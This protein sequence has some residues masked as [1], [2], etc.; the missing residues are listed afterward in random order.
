MVARP[1]YFSISFFRLFW[2]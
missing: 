2:Y 1:Q